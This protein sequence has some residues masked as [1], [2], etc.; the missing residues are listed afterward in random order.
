MKL[1]QKKLFFLIIML[2]LSLSLGGAYYVEASL[3]STSTKLSN[4]QPHP[5]KQIKDP[6]KQLTNGNFLEKVT[7]T[8]GAGA[9]EEYAL[10]WVNDTNSSPDP[11][12]LLEIGN[13]T[14]YLDPGTPFN[15]SEVRNRPEQIIYVINQSNN[16]HL[17]I[18]NWD[19][20][21]FQKTAVNLTND[22]PGFVPHSMSVGS[23]P[24]SFTAG[25]N[26]ENRTDEARTIF[27]SNKTGYIAAVIVYELFNEWTN[28]SLGIQ[29]Y[30]N[31]NQI[32]TTVLGPVFMNYPEVYVAIGRNVTGTKLSSDKSLDELIIV[33]NGNITI[34]T[35]PFSATVTGTNNSRTISGSLDLGSPDLHYDSKAFSSPIAVISSDSDSDNLDEIVIAY[36]TSKMSIIGKGSLDDPSGTNLVEDFAVDFL[37][38]SPTL[39][40][41]SAWNNMLRGDAI[42]DIKFGDFDGTSHKDLVIL[43]HNTTFFA[44]NFLSRSY[45][46]YTLTWNQSFGLSQTT[47]YSFAIG[48]T[49]NDRY[50]NIPGIPHGNELVFAVNS[51]S[52]R[53]LHFLVDDA[54]QTGVNPLSE[55]SYSLNTPAILFSIADIDHNGKNE[56]L[57]VQENGS[58]R[59]WEHLY[60]I[61]P[62]FQE[63]IVGQDSV[64]NVQV[65]AVEL[66]YNFSL[67]VDLTQTGLQV[68][69]QEPLLFFD[70]DPGSDML[71]SKM[72]NYTVR[73]LPTYTDFSCN[74]SST[75]KI[76][77]TV[78]YPGY[79]EALPFA[80]PYFPPTM[81]SKFELAFSTPQIMFINPTA[82]DT[83]H[84]IVKIQVDIS[85]SP[86]FSLDDVSLNISDENP[87]PEEEYVVDTTSMIYN[88]STGYWDYNWDATE[89][90]GSY[91]INI[92][93]YTTEERTA[94][95]SINVIVYNPVPVVNLLE[96]SPYDIVSGE[97]D[98]KLSIT[99]SNGTIDDI[100][101]TIYGYP[102]VG[103]YNSVTKEWDGTWDST[104]APNGLVEIEVTVTYTFEDIQSQKSDVYYIEINNPTE[105]TTTTTTTTS[106][107]SMT[108]PIATTGL[109]Y[110]V[111]L[112]T[113]ITTGL[114]V[115][116]RKRMR[117][118][119]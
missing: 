17:I 70:I 28:E 97:I 72:A 82:D 42:S 89:L 76:D 1:Y 88:S 37:N 50:N 118:S 31:T 108:T 35:S 109:T 67:D 30:E 44:L 77:V 73:R 63:G 81:T 91:A 24:G 41:A 110:V 87:S 94:F 15:D 20:N 103:S 66:L 12:Y 29:L 43:C 47:A 84:N 6:P 102:V 54:D 32:K 10:K 26:G 27:L 79:P 11:I 39:L 71:V 61:V 93:A 98:I 99:L 83:V 13:I 112:I 21:N 59:I 49:D 58:L 4:A 68:V 40:N 53:D 117:I 119:G 114:V 65:T 2:F 3:T 45:P 8:L 25:V 14:Q 34:H 55:A 62:E 23:F 5:S 33:S 16:P 46:Y 111:L 113:L 107:T 78:G 96:P 18:L 51:S 48:D 9:M 69:Q 105:T 116:K 19:G 64:V 80:N 74:I 36:D 101:I 22:L 95:D 38:P 104:E 92:G 60:T 115:L 75:Y 106:T 57:I 7:G 90:N 86:K 85:L 56:L 100:S 52:N